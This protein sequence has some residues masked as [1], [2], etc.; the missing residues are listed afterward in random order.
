MVQARPESDGDDGA[1]VALVETMFERLQTE[2]CVLADTLGQGHPPLQ[3]RTSVL[4][5]ETQTEEMQKNHGEEAGSVGCCSHQQQLVH[6]RDVAE[7][8]RQLVEQKETS[9]ADLTP[10]LER[11]INELSRENRLW[12]QKV[13][14]GQ[15]QLA[16]LRRG[17]TALRDGVEECKKEETQLSDLRQQLQL[18]RQQLQERAAADERLV[19]VRSQVDLLILEKQHQHEM[20]RGLRADLA[21][22]GDEATAAQDQCQAQRDYVSQLSSQLTE[23][24][25]NNQKLDQQVQQLTAEHAG[26]AEQ[27]ARLEEDVHAQA[28]VIVEHVTA[29]LAEWRSENQRLGQRVD[30]QA[31]TIA[32]LQMENRHLADRL[33]LFHTPAPASFPLGRPPSLHKAPSPLESRPSC[34][35]SRRALFTPAE[36]YPLSLTDRYPG[37]FT[38]GCVP[39][40]APSP[41]E[42]HRHSLTEGCPPPPH[43]RSLTDECPPRPHRHSGAPLPPGP[44]TPGT[45]GSVDHVP[46]RESDLAWPWSYP[47]HGGRH[48]H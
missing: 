11:E 30:Q 32:A 9:D 19:Q 36:G 41:A 47:R 27:R 34:P 15:R 38:E 33:S 29:W 2:L 18:A 10:S 6:Q 16:D 42:P 8:L 35:H 7:Y 48:A 45:P 21:A 23:Q 28:D 39:P 37:S 14:D 3:G 46:M 26:C 5:A 20:I 22:S 40:A 25:E 31:E 13:T 43:R 24:R 17:L 12:R 1:D 4:E 44:L